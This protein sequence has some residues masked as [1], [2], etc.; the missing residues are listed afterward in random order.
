MEARAS[1]LVM[2]CIQ[3]RQKRRGAVGFAVAAALMVV[4]M[5][6]REVQFPRLILERLAPKRRRCMC[7]FYLC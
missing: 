5:S 3:P 6:D 2:E 4:R 1:P 7:L